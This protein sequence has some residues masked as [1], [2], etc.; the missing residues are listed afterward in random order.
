MKIGTIREELANP[1]VSKTWEEDY[2]IPSVMY[3][4]VFVKS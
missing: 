3:F 1:K 4:S 2:L